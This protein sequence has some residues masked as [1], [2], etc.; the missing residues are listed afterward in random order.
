MARVI[1][2]QDSNLPLKTSAEQDYHLH[3]NPNG[4]VTPVSTVRAVALA[5][6]VRAHARRRGA[7]LRG[8]DTGAVQLLEPSAT[9]AGRGIDE[10]KCLQ[11]LAFLC[12][13]MMRCVV[14]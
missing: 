7:P 9:P 14:M 10:P 8:C 11:Y 1:P 2:G 4:P 5:A 6:G 13:R 12:R 3:G